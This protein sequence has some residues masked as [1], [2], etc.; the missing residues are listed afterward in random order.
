M[1]ERV[2]IL[3]GRKGEDLEWRYITTGHERER[4]DATPDMVPFSE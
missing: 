4:K 1:S 2:H 3:G